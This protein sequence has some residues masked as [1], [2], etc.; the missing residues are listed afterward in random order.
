MDL[1]ERMKH[2]NYYLFVLAGAA[3]I[4]MMMLTVVDVILREFGLAIVGTYEL[5]GFAAVV[6]IGFC[7][8]YTTSAKSHI[9]VEFFTMKMSGGQYTVCFV[10]TRLIGICLFLLVGYNLLLLGT[11]LFRSGEVSMTL[12]MPF[13]PIAFCIGLCC[14][15]QVLTQV[16]D[17]VAALRRKP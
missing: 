11:T 8:P 3:M 14:F 1:H 15:L 17:I 7:I 2:L 16:V 9:T 4:F 10:F 6:V 13:Y 5:V 12:R